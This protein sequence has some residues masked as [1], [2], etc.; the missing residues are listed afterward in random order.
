MNNF[1]NNNGQIH[2]LRPS[3]TTCTLLINHIITPPPNSSALNN[4][5]IIM[6][7]LNSFK[8]KGKIKEK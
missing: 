1:K 4:D 6:S 7:K 2:V 8:F 5:C 3:T